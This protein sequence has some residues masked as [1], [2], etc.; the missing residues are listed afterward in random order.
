[1]WLAHHHEY[2]LV[3]ALCNIILQQLKTKE[4]I[5]REEFGKRGKTGS[6]LNQSVIEME[7]RI[8]RAN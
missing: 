8:P 4:G 2:A 6:F 1:M 5:G 7:G 3:A